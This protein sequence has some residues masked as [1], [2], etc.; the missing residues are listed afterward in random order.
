MVHLS[1]HIISQSTPWDNNVVYKPDP[2]TMA[3]CDDHIDMSHVDLIQ[4]ITH[5]RLS[6][7]QDHPRYIDEHCLHI[8]L[9]SDRLVMLFVIRYS[10]LTKI[11]KQ[12]H[13]Q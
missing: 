3:Y 6:L 7:P 2:V 5:L 10:D 8:V 11:V 12:I 9:M 1:M 4:K 13:L